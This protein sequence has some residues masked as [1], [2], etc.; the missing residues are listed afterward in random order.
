MSEGERA[1]K[2]IAMA[3]CSCQC[4]QELVGLGF[5]DQEPIRLDV[6]FAIAAIVPGQGVVAVL[7]GKRLLSDEQFEHLLK[8][9]RTASALDGF[10][11]VLFELALIVD[12]KH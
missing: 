10:G 7:R 12:I 2:Q 9:F 3:A 11:V 8:E 4:E 6:A 1:L 5:V